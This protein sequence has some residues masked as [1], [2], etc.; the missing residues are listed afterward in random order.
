MKIIKTLQ[1]KSM[2]VYPASTEAHQQ[3]TPQRHHH[4]PQQQ[5]P[6]QQQ[7]PRQR[8][9][10]SKIN[11]TPFT[12][13]NT[14]PGHFVPIVYTPLSVTT[15]NDANIRYKPI[16]HEEITDE[17]QE[18]QQQQQEQ[19]EHQQHQYRQQKKQQQQMHNIAHH[20]AEYPLPEAVASSVQSGHPRAHQVQFLTV[21]ATPPPAAT[22]THP[23]S[24]Y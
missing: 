24:R 11:L 16:N 17:E 22:A 15:N 23:P 2:L 13:T 8:P 10:Q 21:T 19:Q 9:K 12:S 1:H 6:L 3:H 4:H 14:V 5:L 20:S 18:Q 7:Y